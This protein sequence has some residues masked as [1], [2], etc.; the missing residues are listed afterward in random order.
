MGI[1][2]QRASRDDRQ[3]LTTFRWERAY[4]TYGYNRKQMRSFKKDFL[5][6]LNDELNEKDHQCI[7][8]TENDKIQ[9]TIYWK[10][11]SFVMS[12]KN[13]QQGLMGYVRYLEG[14]EGLNK[15]VL[16][17]LL[18]RVIGIAKEEQWMAIYAFANGISDEIFMEAGFQKK[19]DTFILNL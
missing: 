16:K 5:H 10:T 6:F 7:F 2:Y 14:V 11:Q 1:R 12:Y 9:A 4:Q 15:E 19:D 17:A 8:A 13:P 3:A 18:Q